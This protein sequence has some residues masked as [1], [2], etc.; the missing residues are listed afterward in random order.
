MNY[1]GLTSVVSEG[2]RLRRVHICPLHPRTNVRGFRR[3]IIS[4]LEFY[5]N[6]MAKRK[7]FRQTIQ[8]RKNRKNIFLSILKFFL[9]IIIISTA[10]AVF[11][12]VYYAKDLPRPEKFTEKRQ[13]EST[14]I[15]DR[16]GEILLYEIYGEEKR[17][18]V[19]LET[20]PDYLKKAV[21]ATE[22]NN[23][24]THRGIDLKAITRAILADF[25][26]KSAA[27]GA[28]TISQQLIR[29]SFLSR[30]K[31][32]ERKTR[33]IILTL[34]LER[35]YSKDQ[36]LYW[37][38]N[39]I[40]FGQNAY[41]VEEA[42]QTYFKKHISEI[43][44]AEAALLTA[45]IRSPSYLSPYG[46]NQEELINRKNFVL[47]RMANLGFI[48]QETAKEAKKEELVFV[49]PLQSIKAP[50]FV[51]YVKDYLET[52]YGEDLKEKGLKVY[53]T[54]DWKFQEIAEA[55]VQEGVKRNETY[56]AY[57]GAL[58]ALDPKTGEILSM[59]GSADWFGE[60]YPEGCDLTP[61]VDC[62][63]DPMVNVATYKIGRQPGSAF[64]PF[65]YATA[66]QKGYDDKY[67]VVDEETNFGIWG[68]KPYIPQ[69]YDG[70]FRG[71]V[72]LREALAQ[73]LNVP[74]V[75]VLDFLAGLPDSIETAKNMGI[76][77]LDKP[78]SFYG[79]AKV[80]GGGE[81]KLLDMVSAYG[82]FATEGQ[83][84]PPTAVLKIEDSQGNIIEQNKK[85]PIRVLDIETCRLMSDILSDN[86]A[87]SPIFGLNSSLHIEGYQVAAKTGT[88]QYYK[89][90]WTIGYT[91][92]IVVGVWV[93]NSDNSP[94]GKI[95]AASS[96]APIWKNFMLQVLPNYPRE[97]FVKP[98]IS[99]TPT[100]LPTL[101]PE[102]T[103]TSIPTPSPSP[104]LG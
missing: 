99:P 23:F 41:G 95:P 13:I 7:F 4:F 78:P 38:L 103:P 28:S 80:L 53:T 31:T 66:F 44:L 43:T 58:V 21:I 45:L 33:E 32:V 83:R 93:G 64:K 10:G 63:F 67:I 75:K 69:N 65:V 22:D 1:H 49:K 34:E 55:A 25:K 56:H 50:H 51:L 19:P 8:K 27:Q 92:S 72:T 79:L 77:T 24:Y 61:E 71:P 20:I 52:K 90:G 102:S 46:E 12:F 57:N 89:D 11:V 74:S 104:N 73:S 37:Y 94:M 29:S 6:G 15:Y 86:E 62:L 26:I 60:S 48:S 68:G 5:N 17:T 30:E 39:Q 59:V 76:T 70:K 14:K 40:P 47:D 3:A 85:T 35:R 91:P 36:I 54:L 101:I 9:G 96:G 98:T 88:T 16:T 2:L 42:S 87:R 84:I 97:N 100:P 18:I 82:V 81:V